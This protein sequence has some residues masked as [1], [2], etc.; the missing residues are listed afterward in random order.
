MPEHGSD[1]HA[2]RPPNRSE[3]DPEFARDDAHALR[4]WADAG[5]RPS[6]GQRSTSASVPRRPGLPLRGWAVAGSPAW[7]R[8][9]DGRPAPSKRLSPMRRLSPAVPAGCVRPDLGL[10][11]L[12]ASPDPSVFT[13]PEAFDPGDPSMGLLAVRDMYHSDLR[14][15]QARQTIDVEQVHEAHASAR[16]EHVPRYAGPMS[17]KRVDG[18]TYLCRKVKGSDRSLGPER[19]AVVA[20]GQCRVP[21]RRLR[22]PSRR[23]ARPETLGRQLRGAGPR[24]ARLRHG[25]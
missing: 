12:H 10:L 8:R 5:G 1:R 9:P 2:A 16:V 22:A 24:V 14:H 20:P 19:S 6:R 17:W 18:R 3:R 13:S 15:A 11:A 7:S 25:A 4:R 23:G 21:M